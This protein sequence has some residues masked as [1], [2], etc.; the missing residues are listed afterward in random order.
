MRPFAVLDGPWGRRLF[1]TGLLLAVVGTL[2][3]RIRF[4]DNHTLDTGGY[5][6]NIIYGV[7]RIMNGTPLYT[8][9]E[10]PPFAIIQYG[11]LHMWTMATLA[12]AVG[13]DASDVQGVYVLTRIVV[14][15]LNVLACWALYRVC[16]VLGLQAWVAAGMAA[17]F[18]TGMAVFYYLRPDSTYILFFWL[19][20]LTFLHVVRAE[21]GTVTWTQLIPS[22]L[23]GALAVC[24]KQTGVLTFL[25]AIVFLLHQRR[26]SE[27]GKYITLSVFAGIGVVGILALHGGLV[28]AYKN[29]VLGVANDVGF[30]WLRSLMVTKYFLIGVPV[31]VLGAMTA[32]PWL[33][34]NVSAMH[35]YLAVGTF[36]AL[37][38]ALLTG[39]KAGMNI[40]YFTEHYV[41][42][43][44]CIAVAGTEQPRKSGVWMYRSL[45]LLL[46]ALAL[47][48]TAMYFS[49]FEV[50]HYYADDPQTY[51]NEQLLTAELREHGLQPTDA[52]VLWHR[53]YLELFLPEQT[54][55]DQK[56]IVYKSAHHGRIDHDEFFRM[57]DDGRATYVIAPEAVKDITIVGH[58]FN[59]YRPY[60]VAHGF[61]VLV[62]PLAAS[63]AR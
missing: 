35:S 46:P 18:F 60:F 8:D 16:R 29:I 40:N 43:A 6:Q 28:N 1:L 5:D 15:I 9:P 11:P 26:W 45:L 3:F 42:A 58:D 4:V 48:R 47:V 22:V 27:L 55:L 59:H 7:V 36:V 62:H 41:F 10:R 53:G 2:F 37:G 13:V 51:R 49:A 32:M 30:F 44:L 33:R 19:H 34:R 14:L 17:F 38:W 61:R 24:T 52:V 20:V 56:D 50:T 21:R 12:R 23:F 57:A 25:L 31:T 39:L 63:G 54:L